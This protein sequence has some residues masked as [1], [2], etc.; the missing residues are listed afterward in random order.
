MKRMVAVM[1]TAAVTAS[2]LVLAL[3]VA[4][5]HDIPAVELRQASMVQPE[6]AR[7]R[8]NEAIATDSRQ[9]P[10]RTCPRDEDRDK[11]QLLV[12]FLLL[13]MESGASRR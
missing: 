1:M 8:Q 3:S 11:D 2:M 12:L 5:E 9:P 10:A 7:P 6:S 4:G 13:Q